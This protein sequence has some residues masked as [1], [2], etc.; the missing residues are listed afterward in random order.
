M[1]WDPLYASMYISLDRLVEN[2]KGE[3][4]PI[5]ELNNGQTE[6]RYLFIIFL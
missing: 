3:E 2:L 1:G 6:M 4:R 5:C